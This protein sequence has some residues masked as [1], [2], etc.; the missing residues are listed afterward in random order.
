[1]HS[2]RLPALQLRVVVR[3]KVKKR[4]IRR[5][6]EGWG[7]MDCVRASSH[8]LSFMCCVCTFTYVLGTRNTVRWVIWS[9]IYGLFYLSVFYFISPFLQ[10]VYN[11]VLAPRVSSRAGVYVCRWICG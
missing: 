8:I 10:P 1:M 2:F 7:E 4:K 6:G 9:F 3:V 5:T 11:V